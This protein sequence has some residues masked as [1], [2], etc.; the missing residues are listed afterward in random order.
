MGAA[1]LVFCG[2]VGGITIPFY[3]LTDRLMWRWLGLVAACLGAISG[4]NAG[5]NF[6]AAILLYVVSSLLGM[7]IGD[8]MFIRS[9]PR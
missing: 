8:R 1:L 3:V 6:T 9:S 4:L 7:I 5:I 2:V